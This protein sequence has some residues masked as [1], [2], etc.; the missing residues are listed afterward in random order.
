MESFDEI[1]EK[2]SLQ[3]EAEQDEMDRRQQKERVVREA[4]IN[5]KARAEALKPMVFQ[6][7]KLVAKALSN[8]GDIKTF[9]AKLA[10]QG[11]TSWFKKYFPGDSMNP[12][13]AQPTAGQIRRREQRN[14]AE[15]QANSFR[16]WNLNAKWSHENGS[17]EDAYTTSEH[18]FLAPDGSVLN[19]WFSSYEMYAQNH[20]IVRLKPTSYEFEGE[21]KL[22]VIR[23]GLARLAVIGGLG[24]EL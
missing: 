23:Q 24:P 3:L 8:R 4:Q 1:M 6:E 18:Y 22:T 15:R 16:V 14:E 9:R 13:N 7:A 17:G 10:E 20:N 2:A 5:S 19:N 11:K 21:A 12:H